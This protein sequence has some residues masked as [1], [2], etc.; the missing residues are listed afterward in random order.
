MATHD[1]KIDKRYFDAIKSGEKTFE[2]RFNDRNYQAGDVLHLRETVYSA[3]QMKAGCPRLF[4][5]RET[6][7]QVLSIFD[8]HA[9]KGGWVIMSITVTK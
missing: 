3:E 8:H 6:K 4:S 1:L 2:L 5:G 7:V 9:I